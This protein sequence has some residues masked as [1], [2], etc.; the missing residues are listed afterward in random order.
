MINYIIDSF[1]LEQNIASV[2][3]VTD[4]RKVNHQMCK[5]TKM[6]TTLQKR[7]RLL[8]EFLEKHSSFEELLVLMS[9]IAPNCHKL[10]LLYYQN[11]IDNLE[12]EKHDEEKRRN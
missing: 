7:T 3:H 10:L 12:K 2:N 8:A 11:N 4:L 5:E 9:N 1:Y 6:E